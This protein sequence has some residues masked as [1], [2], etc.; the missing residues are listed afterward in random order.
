MHGLDGGGRGRL[1]RV[2]HGDDGGQSAVDGGV[3]RRLALVP[4]AG[5]VFGEGND[6]VAQLGHVAV[7]ADLDAAARDDTR[8][9]L[10]GD[11][12]E[13]FG[14][15]DAQA[16]RGGGRDQGAGHRVFRLAFDGGNQGQDVILVKAVGHA[17]VG[18][19]GAA[20]GQGAGLVEGDDLDPL[21]GLQGLALAEQDAQLGGA[22]H[23]DHDGGRSG[24]THGAGAGDDQHRDSGDQGH[25]ERRIGREQIPDGEGQDGDAHDDRHEPA[26]D[27]I[28]QGLNGQLGALGGF[29]HADDLGQHGFGA[30]LLRLEAE[31]ARGVQG[32]A[33]DLGAGGLLNRD[34][35]AGQHGFVEIGR[36]LGH[37]A[38]DGDALAGA[39]DDDV[40]GLDGVDRHVLFDAVAH[41]AGG[42]GLHRHQAADGLAGLTL[43]AGLDPAPDQDQGDD[44]G[45]G[46]EIDV[47][48]AGGQQAGGEGGDRREGPGGARAQHHQGVHVRRAAQ[49][50]GHALAEEDQARNEQDEAG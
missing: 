23:A 37:H 35:F 21:Q 39:D 44:D 4:Q 14:A 36:A 47:G 22:A 49:Q 5:G 15:G 50:G 27:A 46:F 40:A 42:L 20:G 26:G 38:V 13:V 18:Q 3:E 12:G 25:A 31:G 9:T 45:G 1:D 33:D 43:G 11:G 29:D 6:V 41:D 30:D 10:A 2:G 24:Q 28:H 17:Q 19:F 16:A 7:G 8:H 34:G 32:A 48:R